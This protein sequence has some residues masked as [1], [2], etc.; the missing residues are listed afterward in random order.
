MISIKIKDY[1]EAKQALCELKG[2]IAVINS[3]R[4]PRSE[5]L[6]VTRLEQLVDSFLVVLN[7]L[8]EAGEYISKAEQDRQRVI[9]EYYTDKRKYR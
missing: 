9:T 2:N 1:T 3:L 8:P 6:L 7:E 5:A 4:K